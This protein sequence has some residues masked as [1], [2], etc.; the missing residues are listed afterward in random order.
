MQ[1]NRKLVVGRIA[2]AAIAATIIIVIQG[3]NLERPAALYSKDLANK[4]R[5]L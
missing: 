5:S 1:T 3:A 2:V 4:Q